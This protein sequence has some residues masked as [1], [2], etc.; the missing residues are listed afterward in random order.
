MIT[1]SNPIRRIAGSLA[2][3]GLLATSAVHAQD[4]GFFVTSAGSGNGGDLGGLE[5]ADAHC[6]SLAEAAGHGDRTWRAYLSTQGNDAVHARDRIGSG[7][8]YNVNG[9]LI[10]NNL[11]ELHQDSVDITHETALDE[12]GEMVPYVHLNP[13]GTAIN[14]PDQ[15][16]PVQHDIL[17]GTMAD[18]MAFGAEEDRTCGN[19]MSSD[20]GNAMVGHSDRR[21]LQPGLSPWATAHPSQGC[22]Q[23]SLVN[24]GGSGRF[25]CFAAD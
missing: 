21:S 4:A 2:L 25:Y 17:T 22:G 15:P 3:A 10:A 16:E 18:G 13:D 1:K 20:E 14:P 24:T 6:Q 23:Q 9:D 11:D 8:W 12:N 5:G 19:W 7:P